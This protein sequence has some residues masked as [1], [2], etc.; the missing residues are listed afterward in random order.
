V[1]FL[2]LGFGLC[3]ISAFGFG[4][5]FNLGL[6]FG[7]GTES[8]VDFIMGSDFEATFGLAGGG[9][10]GGAAGCFL[11][12]ISDFSAGFCNSVVISTSITCTGA[13]IG[14]VEGNTLSQPIRKTVT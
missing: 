12:I 1:G 4:V 14:S 13:I 8:G 5:F 6:G 11:T 10:G 2:I 7:T 9:A 3:V